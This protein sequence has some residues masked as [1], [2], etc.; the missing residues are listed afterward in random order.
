MSCWPLLVVIIIISI[1]FVVPSFSFLLTFYSSSFVLVANIIIFLFL[2]RRK[3][4]SCLYCC[5][6]LAFLVSSKQQKEFRNILCIRAPSTSQSWSS[7]FSSC[8]GYG[9]V[10]YVVIFKFFDFPNSAII[11]DLCHL[12]GR[13]HLHCRPCLE[14]IIVISSMSS[15]ALLFLPRW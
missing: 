15:S 9:V 8:R 1:N 6:V 12:L 7:L 2:N 10:V 11:Y 13:H 3:Y 4:R 5:L 14:I